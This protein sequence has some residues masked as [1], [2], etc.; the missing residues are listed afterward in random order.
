M[1]GYDMDM[2]TIGDDISWMFGTGERLGTIVLERLG[3]IR[4]GRDLSLR[5]RDLLMNLPDRK[6]NRMNGYDYSRDGLYFVTCCVQN[7]ACVFGNITQDEMRLNKYR[8][9]AEK[10]WAW[11]QEQY[12]YI[13]SHAFVVMPNHI[14]AILEIN[15]EIG[16]ASCRERVSKFV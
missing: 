15:Q 6:L 12:P 5:E 11:L 4:T 1:I 7:M 8:L 13:I 2:K 16:R 10:Q 14:H 9:I 3:T